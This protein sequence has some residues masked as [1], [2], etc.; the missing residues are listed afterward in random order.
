MEIV[1]LMTELVCCTRFNVRFSDISGQFNVQFQFTC[2]RAP[3]PRAAMDLLCVEPSPTRPGASEKVFNLL[4]IRR[5]ARGEG[6]P[7]IEP[8][9]PDPQSS[10]LPLCQRGEQAQDYWW[11]CNTRNEPSSAGPLWTIYIIERT[12]LTPARGLPT[13]L[14]PWMHNLLFF[15]LQLNQILIAQLCRGTHT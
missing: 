9:Y 3:T 10:P 7:G 15:V 11:K 4:A 8:G 13:S 14:Y 2:Y 1:F 6:L 5:P 12:R